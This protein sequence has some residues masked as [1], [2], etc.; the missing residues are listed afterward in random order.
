MLGA[1]LAGL[2]RAPGP[3]DVEALDGAPAELVG[4]STARLATSLRADLA[5]ATSR[6]YRA[7]QRRGARDSSRHG[8]VLIVAAALLDCLWLA[9]LHPR[10]LLL[11]VAL[12][13]ALGLVAAA[14]YVAIA[15]RARRRPEPFVF[16]ALAGVDAATIALGTLAPE[17]GLV[18][19]GY[20]L[21]LPTIVALMIPWATRTH[22]TWLALHGVAVLAY[23]ALAPAWSLDGTLGDR[24]DKLPLLV[25]AITV[26]LF[27]HLTGLRA[28]VGSFVH[29][30]HIKALNR[31]ARRDRA[32]LDRLNTILEETTRTDGLTGLKNRL[33]LKLDLDVIR[34]RIARH[35]ERFGMLVLDLDRFKAIN[36]GSGHVA[37]DGVLRAVA[38]AF[39]EALR[40]EDGVYRYG[41]EEFVALVRV[42][43]PGDALAAAERMRRVVED[44]GLPNPGNPPHDRVTV[45]VGVA[46]IGP[47]DL[48]VD[49]DGWFARADAVL[50]RAKAR[51]RN[52]CETESSAGDRLEN[53][54][55][56]A[57]STT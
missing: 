54:A 2:D 17:L 36:D 42:R 20:L 21:L 25:V 46:V 51:G 3:M 47:D 26:S 33:S 18:A 12:N 48:E 24:S 44:L 14:M 19:A 40:P 29:I 57:A 55:R 41:G 9:P 5:M 49:D 45:S 22:L 6:R 34:A 10:H 8:M 30:E 53:A 11:V 7:S 52:R 16:V 23:T 38:R 35:H 56:Q 31:Q 28:R 1:G 50:Y 13:G 43:R 37:G 27:G 39:A 15:T 32:R 4:P